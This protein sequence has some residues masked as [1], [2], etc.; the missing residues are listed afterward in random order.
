MAQSNPFT[1]CFVEQ[2][3]G[4]L[5][6]KTQS[7]VRS[8]AAKEVRRRR[9]LQQ[10]KRSQELNTAP[11]NRALEDLTPQPSKDP[12]L[13]VSESSLE[14]QRSNMQWWLFMAGRGAGSGDQILQQR[15]PS[16]L[17]TTV[18]AVFDPFASMVEVSPSLSLRYSKDMDVIKSHGK[19]VS[20]RDWSCSLDIRRIILTLYSPLSN[21][22]LL[23]GKYENSCI[24]GGTANT[25]SIGRHI[26]H[27]ICKSFDYSRAE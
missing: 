13:D 12:V 27:G 8:H 16:P 7:A 11:K 19:L 9:R 3:G 5:D 4:S 26:I 2:T 22:F 1:F 21:R 24:S 25:G 18:S 23:P 15:P 14:R 10:Q 20:F 17:S 6:T